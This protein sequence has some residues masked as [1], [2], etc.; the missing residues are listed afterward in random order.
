[1]QKPREETF[2]KFSGDLC[3]KSLNEFTNHIFTF[4]RTYDS[5]IVNLNKTSDNLSTEM[6][7]F[8]LSERYFGRPASAK[9]GL[10]M[11][12]S[13]IIVCGLN[14]KDYK[15]VDG[16]G[17]SHYN[18]VTAELLL[19]VLKHFYYSEPNLFESL[20][21]SFPIAGFDGTLENRMKKTKAEK[22]LEAMTAAAKEEAEKGGG[23]AA[24]PATP[25]TPATPPAGASGG[26]PGTTT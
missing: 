6:T 12:D 26:T 4:S 13:L 5:V 19:S 15:L 24:T 7:L 16:S 1:M 20:Y 11:I 22:A 9:N 18:L 3:I 2:V 14:P 23:P 25:S 21:N 8:A 17:V 10:K